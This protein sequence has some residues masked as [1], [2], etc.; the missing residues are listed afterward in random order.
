[1]I[2]IFWAGDDEF[3]PS[4]QILFNENVHFYFNAEDLSVI[5]DVSIGTLKKIGT[6]E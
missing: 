4:S 5:G 2:F 1:L 3:P 6:M